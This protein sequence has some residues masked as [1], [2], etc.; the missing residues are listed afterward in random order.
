MPIIQ[1][2]H[3]LSFDQEEYCICSNHIVLFRIISEGSELR[4]M[5]ATAPEDAAEFRA[6]DDQQLLISSTLGVFGDFDIEFVMKTDCAGRPYVEAKFSKDNDI[7]HVA[8]MILDRMGFKDAEVFALREMKALHD[9]FATDDG[10]DAY[11]SD[12]MWVTA[13][14]RLVER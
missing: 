10:E 14:G 11:L 8:T 12:G 4:L 3:K 9:E 5:T 2:S 6:F 13:D 1:I 7:N